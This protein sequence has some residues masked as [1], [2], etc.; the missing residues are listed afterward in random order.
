MELNYS[1]KRSY[2]V[3]SQTGKRL[4]RIGVDRKLICA[5]VDSF[6]SNIQ[7]DTVL[8]PVFE[9]R[10]HGEWAPHLEKMYDFW[11]TVIEGKMAYSGDPVRAHMEVKSI[12]LEHFELWIELFEKTLEDVCDNEE[13]IEVFLGPAKRM[14]RALSSRF[15]DSGDSR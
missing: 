9:S 1:T 8:G 10:L 14:A 12:E 15:V 13:Q 7:K 5:V 4:E 6:Y 3:E 2:G 11:T